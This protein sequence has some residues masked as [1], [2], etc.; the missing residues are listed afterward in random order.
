MSQHFRNRPVLLVLLGLGLGLLVGIGMMVGTLTAVNRPQNAEL[1]LPPSLLHAAASHGGETMAIA[2][3]PIDEDV[4]GLYILDFLTGDLHCY[5]L[6]PRMF[7]QPRASAWITS[8]KHN[9]VND[10]GVQQG[11]KPDFAMVTGVVNFQRQPG[12]PLAPAQSAV[13]VLDVN[14]GNFAA[15]G[16]MWNRTAARAGVAQQAVWRPLAAGKGR[17]LEIRD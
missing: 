14:S 3:G 12:N 16:V 8:T 11:K 10:L 5:V 15:Y 13:Y 1:M 9:V 6:N 4:E 7:T 17:A 2:T